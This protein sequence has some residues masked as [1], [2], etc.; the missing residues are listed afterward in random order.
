MHFHGAL[1]PRAKALKYK[2]MNFSITPSLISRA[3][4]LKLIANQNI[5][6]VYSFTQILIF[7]ANSLLSAYP[8]ICKPFQSATFNRKSEYYAVRVARPKPCYFMTPKLY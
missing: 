1:N 8:I 7:A 4:T 3:N 6:E 5:L 2:I